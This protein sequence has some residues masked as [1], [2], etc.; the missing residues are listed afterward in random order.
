MH[1]KN[2]NK[3]SKIREFFVKLH[4][5]DLESNQSTRFELNFV[6]T[7]TLHFFVE[8]NLGKPNENEGGQ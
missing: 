1:D 2:A 5:S 7:Y 4:W 8:Q 3:I 6:V